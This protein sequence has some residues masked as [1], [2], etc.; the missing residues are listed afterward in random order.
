MPS[1]PQ[2]V[3]NQGNQ[4]IGDHLDVGGLYSVDGDSNSLPTLHHRQQPIIG[5]DLGRNGDARG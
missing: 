1:G 4:R 5:D 2:L 3:A